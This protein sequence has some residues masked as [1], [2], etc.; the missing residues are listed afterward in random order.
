MNGI[1]LICIALGAALGA[2]LITYFVVSSTKNA[3][4]KALEEKLLFE[5]EAHKEYVSKVESDHKTALERMEQH[6]KEILSATKVALQAENEKALKAREESLKQEAAQTI[7]T[8]AGPLKQQIESMT[9]AFEE[10]KEAHVRE[11]SSI[12]TQFEQTAKEIG[13]HTEKI[14]LRADKLSDALRNSNKIQGNWG[15][16]QLENIFDQEGFIMGRDYDREKYLRDDKGNVVQNQNTGKKLRPDFIFHFPDN[17]DVIIDA[18]VNLSAYVDW[19]NAESQQEK[20]DACKRN[21]AALN[22]QINKLSEKKYDEYL[23]PGRRSIPYVIMYVGNYGSLA[24]ARTLDPLI[25]NRA[26]R[27][28]VIITTEETIMPLLALIRCSWREAEQIRNQEEIVRNARM[29]IDRVA[30]L[31]AAHAE[32]GTALNKALDAHRLCSVKLAQNGS[33][34]VTAAKN[35]ER[36]GVS[37]KEEKMKHIDAAI[38]QAEQDANLLIE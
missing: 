22:S 36:L 28:N 11:I 9:K 24:L 18:K 37:A 17:T 38:V 29:M 33:S 19:H 6:Q 25:V 31:C 2:T 30:E 23:R 7:Q 32:V 10:Q 16:M 5:R 20:D 1:L 21:L 3:S 26:Y 34:I 12:K 13:T 14:G 8:V 4:L 35:V 15:E 27:S